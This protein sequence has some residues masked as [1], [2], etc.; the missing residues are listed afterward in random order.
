VHKT[1]NYA[2]FA[3]GR[4]INSKPHHNLLGSFCFVQKHTLRSSLMRTR[5]EGDPQQTAQCVC[6]I[7]C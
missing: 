1:Y 6:S 7:L 4:V 5:P 3:A 2:N